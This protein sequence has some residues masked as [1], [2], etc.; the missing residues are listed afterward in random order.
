MRCIVAGGFLAFAIVCAVGVVKDLML[1]HWGLAGRGTL[2]V[3]F[4]LVM[5]PVGI[6]ALKVWSRA[7]DAVLPDGK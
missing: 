4:C 3:V 7:L 6:T 2:A 5:I 1:R